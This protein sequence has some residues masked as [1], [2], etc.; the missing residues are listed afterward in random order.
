[1]AEKDEETDDKFKIAEQAI[2]K[3]DA[4]MDLDKEDEALTKWK[5]QL[6]GKA[7]EPYSRTSKCLRN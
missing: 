5:E 3:V 6:L 4:L 1:M 2:K 7:T